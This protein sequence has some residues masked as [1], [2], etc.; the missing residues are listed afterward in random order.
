VVQQSKENAQILVQIMIIK[1]RS[2]LKCTKSTW[3]L[4]AD[5][6]AHCKL[7]D[8]PFMQLWI[9]KVKDWNQGNTKAKGP[10]SK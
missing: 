5:S 4:C 7:G 10:N 2:Y 6:Y 3:M 1:D 9:A 8:F